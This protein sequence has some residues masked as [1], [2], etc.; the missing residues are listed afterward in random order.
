MIGQTDLTYN[1][2]TKTDMIPIVLVIYLYFEEVI[3]NNLLQD[4]I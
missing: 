2:N 1:I 3:D 4:E